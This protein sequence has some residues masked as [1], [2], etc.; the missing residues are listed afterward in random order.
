MAG[1]EKEAFYVGSVGTKVRI[2]RVKQRA[3]IL[4][5]D[6]QRYRHG[7]FSPRKTATLSAGQR[8]RVLQDPTDPRLIYLPTL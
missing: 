1:V 2:N 5:I 3:L 8:L 7:I 6:N 4:E